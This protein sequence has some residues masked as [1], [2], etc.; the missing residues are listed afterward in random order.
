MSRVGRG[1]GE[2]LCL[3][4]T[5]AFFSKEAQWLLVMK[6]RFEREADIAADGPSECCG[7]KKPTDFLQMAD[8]KFRLIKDREIHRS[9]NKT[10]FMN[11]M[12]NSYC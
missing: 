5:W 10:D 1:T 12:M 9:C 3:M 8:Y 7:A 4:S 6:V 2:Q 11:F